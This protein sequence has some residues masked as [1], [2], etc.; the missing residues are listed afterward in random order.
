VADLV[1]F[2]TSRLAE[3]QNAIM[4]SVKKSRNGERV[5]R[6]ESRIVLERQIRAM[7][8]I[9]LDVVN[10]MVQDVESVQRIMAAHRTSV[11]DRVPGFPMH[12]GEY[13]CE[14]C[15]VPGDEAGSNWCLTMRLLAMPYSDHAGYDQKW[16]A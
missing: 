5:D 12:G 6:A 2:L 1:S 8:D 3:R 15:H 11:S 9:E 4:S 16:R 7:A 14:I 13:W 10:Q